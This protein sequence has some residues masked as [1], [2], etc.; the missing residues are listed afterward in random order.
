[1]QGTY[2]ETDRIFG[3]IVMIVTVV[4]LYAIFKADEKRQKSK[5]RYRAKSKLKNRKERY[6]VK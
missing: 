3:L 5:R 4:V 6:C 2:Y 1:M